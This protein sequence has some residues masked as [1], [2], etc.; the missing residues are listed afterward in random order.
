MFK[1]TVMIIL[2]SVLFIV[3]CDE[4]TGPSAQ[5]PSGM[6]FVTI[7]SGSFLMGSP[8]SLPYSP[9]N[10]R[11]VHT[12]TFDYSFE[13]MTTEVTE[14]MWEEVMGVNPVPIPRGSDHPACYISWNYSHEFIAM[15][16]NLDSN[17]TYR[18]P[19]ESEWEYACRAGTTTAY[20][21]GDDPDGTEGD[22]YACFYGSGG[23][24]A[25]AS[26]LP[27]A[28]GLYDMS[29]N[30]KELCQDSWHDDYNGAPSDG[31]FWRASSDSTCIHRGGHSFVFQSGVRSARRGSTNSLTRGDC[32]TGLRLVR[33]SLL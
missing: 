26:K 12:V 30:V 3:S 22:Q 27:N 17:H 19:S 18:L 6:E 7:P 13:I 21:W 25:V 14:G 31:S 9:D 20:Y 10:E 4:A 23:H 1:I 8:E 33:T 5:L 16:N 28:W 2:I 24:H 11:P 15:L 32:N 29:G